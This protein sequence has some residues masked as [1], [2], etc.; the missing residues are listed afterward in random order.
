MKKR[1][2]HRKLRLPVYLEPDE[3]E[4][5]LAVAPP[6]HRLY[7]LL[8]ARAGLR[9]S[10]AARLRHEELIHMVSRQVRVWPGEGRRYG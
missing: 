4:D 10:E 3:L 1:G 8:C 7:F 2:E 9:S 6:R 5:L